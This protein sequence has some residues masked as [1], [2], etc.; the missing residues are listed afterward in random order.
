MTEETLTQKNL[1]NDNKYQNK[2]IEFWQDFDGKTLAY[3]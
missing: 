2:K 3:E 1:Y